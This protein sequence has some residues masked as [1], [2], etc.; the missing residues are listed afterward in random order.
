MYMDNLSAINSLSMQSDIYLF[1][2]GVE[3]LI[4]TVS[5]SSQAVTSVQQLCQRA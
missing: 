3:D 2:S 5:L 4:S 1:R